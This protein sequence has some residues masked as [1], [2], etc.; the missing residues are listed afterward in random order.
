V[1]RV[2]DLL[3]EGNPAERDFALQLL[4]HIEE[5]QK[6]RG[7]HGD[8]MATIWGEAQRSWDS[9][10]KLAK[11]KAAPYPEVF[12]MECVATIIETERSLMELGVPI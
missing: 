4:A 6:R 12:A 1:R 9:A 7:T 2:A 5:I 11:D 8:L 3:S 10:L